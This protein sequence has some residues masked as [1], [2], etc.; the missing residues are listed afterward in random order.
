MQETKSFL[1]KQHQKGEIS[2]NKASCHLKFSFD[3]RKRRMGQSSYQLYRPMRLFCF[4]SLKNPYFPFRAKWN[5]NAEYSGTSR[6]MGRPAFIRAEPECSS[7]P[8]F[9]EYMA[10]G[11]RPLARIYS[12][13][14]LQVRLVTTTLKRDSFLSLVTCCQAVMFPGLKGLVRR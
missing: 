4:H 1:S 3:Y 2:K 12:W 10:L 11:S 6:L 7:L 5:W 14:P 9:T 8:P 13:G